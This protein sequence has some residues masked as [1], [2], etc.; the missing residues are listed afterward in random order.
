MS[1]SCLR[2]GP[3]CA[4][5]LTFL[6]GA[7]E[8]G[9]LG[10]VLE[11]DERNV[12]FDYGF[13]PHD[14]PTYPL[15]PPAL[16]G[17][18]LSHA[19]LD[20]SGMVAWAAGRRRCPV[21]ATR[22]TQY[23]TELLARDSLKIAGL[24]GYPEPFTHEDI[25][26]LQHAWV[27]VRLGRSFELDGLEVT[28]TSAGHIPGST[29]FLVEG[30][31]RTLFTG[32]LNT[33]STRLM[34]PAKPVS[35]DTLI[36]E[37]T[38]AGREHRPRRE[39]E[40][41]FIDAIDAVVERGG[42]AVVPAFAVGRTQEVLLVLQR[43][44]YEVWLDGM[45]RSVC[46]IYLDHPESVKDFPALEAAYEAANVVRNPKGRE[47]ALKGD[48]IVT[49]SGMVEGGPVFY[50]LSKMERD[51]KSAL[52]LT[53]YQVP[54]TGGRQILDEKR[55]EGDSGMHEVA[56]EVRQLDFSAHLGHSQLLKFIRDCDPQ[57]VALVHGDKRELI[58]TEIDK[59]FDV[60]LGRKG[61][62]VERKA[63]R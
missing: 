22:P 9:S 30:E 46:E 19:H 27:D 42:V 14:P 16:D 6:G 2:R 35:C 58:A 43:G 55:Y 45:G 17:L 8:V 12:L 24:E 34:A 39:I 50:Y 7:E 23:V 63:G 48:V 28:P 31:D 15:E 36:V 61:Q 29:M 47:H 56:C 13:S 60:I 1:L 51:R 54:G 10:V 3:W 59:E 18:M 40:S 11:T 21:F 38:Y 32:D 57:R 53:G 25:E 4:L 62:S 52:F 26:M 20:H 44:G 41:E 49:T 33:I 37:S 5:K